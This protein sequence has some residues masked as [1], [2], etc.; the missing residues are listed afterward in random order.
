MKLYCKNCKKSK[1]CSILKRY[2][3]TRIINDYTSEKY[4][5]SD[6]SENEHGDCKYYKPKLI[7]K[8]I[9]FLLYKLKFLKNDFRNDIIKM[10]KNIIKNRRNDLYGNKIKGE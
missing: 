9:Y 4:L 3:C 7:I 8:V 2:N 10:K 5:Y 6:C 1:Y